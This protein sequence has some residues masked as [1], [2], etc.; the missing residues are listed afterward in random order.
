MQE[1]FPAYDKLY[2]GGSEEKGKYP[3]LI[4]VPELYLIIEMG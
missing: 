2:K 3:R 1:S 4:Q